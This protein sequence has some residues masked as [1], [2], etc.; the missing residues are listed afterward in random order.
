MAGE[1]VLFNTP[2]FVLLGSAQDRIELKSAPACAS[3]PRISFRSVASGLQSRKR[4][5]C[6]GCG[7]TG[8]S[9]SGLWAFALR[10]EREA[11]WVSW[12][13][14]LQL[15][16]WVHFSGASQTDTGL[17]CNPGAKT[18]PSRLLHISW[19]RT[20]KTM[21]VLDLLRLRTVVT[22]RLEI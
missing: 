5:R 22:M 7:R 8:R 12:P 10:W 11:F 16:T 13:G 21:I 20:S 6:F 3:L 1:L 18:V 9:T 15:G 17:C 19:H 2:V 4:T 14:F